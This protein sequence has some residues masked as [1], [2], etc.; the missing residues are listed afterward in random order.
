MCSISGGSGL[1]IFT[2]SCLSSPPNS[3]IS[4]LQVRGKIRCADC[5]PVILTNTS[6]EFLLRYCE[7]ESQDINA[8]ETILTSRSLLPY[9]FAERNRCSVFH[10]HSPK[11]GISHP[12]KPCTSVDTVKTGSCTTCIYKIYFTFV[13]NLYRGVFVI[14][15]HFYLRVIR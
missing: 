10:S 4:R 13:G 7:R 5:Q 9:S 3:T 15:S 12:Q 6:L 1:Q 8:L 14:R 11:V 2:W